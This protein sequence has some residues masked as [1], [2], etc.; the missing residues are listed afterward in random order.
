MILRAAYPL[1]AQRSRSAA[2]GL[3]RFLWHV[4][5]TGRRLQRGVRPW[6]WLCRQQLFD[7]K[8]DVL[9]D[10]TK[11]C[12]RNIATLMKRNGGSSTV[13]MP[14]LSVRTSLADFRE[15][16]LSEKRHDL[17]RLEDRRFRHGLCHF[18]GL[19]ADE[20]AAEPGV[21]VFKKHLDHFMEI[22]LQLVERLT[23]AVR[24]GKARY[25]PHVEPRVAVPLND[26][27]EILHD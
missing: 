2:A 21:A 10:L 15:P 13:W 3:G 1:A 18:D 22:R 9:R 23:L 20:R 27:R 17:A 12:R 6:G 11:Q 24:P 25:P 4:R 19:S 14:K 7:R 8:T 26:G 16:Q 5:L